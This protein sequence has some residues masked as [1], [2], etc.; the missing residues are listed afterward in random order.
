MSKVSESFS[1]NFDWFDEFYPELGEGKKAHYA[2]LHLSI[3]A[4]PGFSLLS[5]AERGF[6]WSIILH[7]T[8]VGTSFIQDSANL[9]P[10]SSQYRANRETMWLLKFEQ[11]GIVSS[12]THRQVSKEVIKERKK[13]KK[14]EC[15]SGVS[16]KLLHNNKNL[17]TLIDSPANTKE[18]END[19]AAKKG[20]PKHVEMAEWFLSRFNEICG[21]S[22]RSTKAFLPLMKARLAEGHTKEQFEAVILDRWARWKNS[23][24]MSTDIN[25]VMLLRP[26]NFSNY[27]DMATQ[28]D[29]PSKREEAEKA[30]KLRDA[31]ELREAEIAWFTKMGRADEIKNL[32][33]IEGYTD[34][35]SDAAVRAA[36]AEDFDDEHEA[37]KGQGRG[38]GRGMEQAIRGEHQGGLGGGSSEDIS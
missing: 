20:P 3:L 4:K 34:N 7:C 21:K 10:S 17:P 27:L 1:F 25:P 22:F 12:L 23:E 29:A 18:K 19:A 28:S 30:R 16:E 33:P 15:T 26:L 2:Q 32:P 37:N 9:Q 5:Y 13:E 38:H 35:A 6:L 24:K 31:I 36:M 8:K 14:G 11:L